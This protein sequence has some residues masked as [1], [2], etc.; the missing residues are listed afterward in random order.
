MT[1]LALNPLVSPD[2]GLF[3]WSTVAFLILFFLLSKFAWK[4]IVKALDE[5]E[6][7]I[8]DA[9]SKAEM[10]KAEMAKLI[11]ENEDLL[12]EARLE[13]DN[14]LKEAKEI[15]DQIINDAKDQAKTEGTKLI[16]KAKDEITNQKLAAMAEIKNQVSSLS[17]AIAEKVLRKQLEDQDKQQA[18]V[19]DLLK[20]VKLN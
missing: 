15:K 6:R 2:P 12:K 3:I 10:A 16:E 19:N 8:E 14:I 17:L 20:E 7:S 4:P 9:L 13:R 11:S 1:L 5:R 18:L